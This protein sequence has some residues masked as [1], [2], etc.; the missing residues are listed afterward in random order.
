VAWLAGCV[1]LAWK[2]PGWAMGLLALTAGGPVVAGAILADNRCD[3]PHG[4]I[5]VF[6]GILL[7]LLTVI[8]VFVKRQ[9]DYSDEPWYKIVSGICFKIIL[10]LLYLALLIG[11]FRPFGVIL[12][13]LSMILWFRFRQTRRYSLALNVLS[14]I[15]AA[16][17]QNLPLPMALETAG[18]NRRDPAA[19]IYRQTAQFLCEGKSLSESLRK[20]YR[21]CPAEILATLAAGEAMNQLPQAAAALEQDSIANING[22]EKIRPVHPAYPL[23]VGGM[24]FLI[25]LGLCVFILPTFAEVLHDVTGGQGQLPA[26][27]QALLRISKI[28]MER[29]VFALVSGVL[30]IGMLIGLYVYNRPRRPGRPRLLSRA[31]DWLKW[32]TPGV[33]SF[34]RLRSMQQTIEGL[35]VGLKAGYSF[36]TIVRHTLGLDVNLCYQARL[37]RWLEKIEAGLPIADSAAACG[38]GT[39][40]AWALDETVNKGNTPELLA[41]LEEVTRNRYYYRLNIFHSIL[42]PFVVVGMGGCVGFVVYAMF[43]ATVSMITHTMD[44]SMP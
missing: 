14:T 11:I 7:F 27:T 26:S 16:M 1:V 41:M 29:G 32:H 22:F 31:S 5:L 13:I 37:R 17:R 21:R 19:T 8:L 25:V 42:W 4:P 38:L 20:A 24:T 35:R 23:L 12:F 3:L 28:V 10:A 40:L 43:A 9:S 39:T 44:Y 6:A 36:D 15:S 2:R 33:R 30:L 34:E 18:S